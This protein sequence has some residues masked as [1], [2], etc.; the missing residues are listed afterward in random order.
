MI[1]VFEFIRVRQN[2]DFKSEAKQL[3]LCHSYT[4]KVNHA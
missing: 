3:I 2:S 1:N 4:T